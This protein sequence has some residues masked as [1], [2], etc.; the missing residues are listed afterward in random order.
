MKDWLVS[1][2]AAVAV[3]LIVILTIKFTMPLIMQATRS[4]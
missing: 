3:V 1:F 2:L 4:L